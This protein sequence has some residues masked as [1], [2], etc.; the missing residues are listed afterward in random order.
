MDALWPDTVLTDV[1]NAY[2]AREEVTLL[3]V[4]IKLVMLSYAIG[5]KENRNV[6]TV[7]IPGAFMQADMDDKVL[8]LQS[9]N[10][11]IIK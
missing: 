6:A 3:T 1:N 9:N 7:N 10:V 8:T 5:A 11:N 2:T 4:A